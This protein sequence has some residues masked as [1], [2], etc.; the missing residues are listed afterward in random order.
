MTPEQVH[1][2][3]D[4]LARPIFIWRM[5]RGVLYGNSRASA[6]A[7]ARMD[8]AHREIEEVI[9]SV[10]GPGYVNDPHGALCQS[11]VTGN[12]ERHCNCKQ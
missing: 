12:D 6:S 4:R 8:R 7:Q 9:A 1:Q 5:A 11:K 2:L 3:V 10:L